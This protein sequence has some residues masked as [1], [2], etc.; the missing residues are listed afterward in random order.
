MTQEKQ[1]LILEDIG[2]HSSEFE[3]KLREAGLDYQPVWEEEKSDPERVEIIVHVKKELMAKN[4][5]KYPRLKL[6]AVAF[7]GFD[8][9]DLE[10]CRE[11]DI[12]VYNVPAYSTHSVTELTIG[13]AIALFREIPKSNRIIREGKWKIK[14]GL[15]IFGKKVGI[16]GTGKIGINTA[17]VFKALGCELLGW[18]RTEKDEFKALG[19]T[20]IHDKKEF[21]SQCD[22][23]SIHLPFNQHT[24]QAVGKEELSAM[25]PTAYLINTARG[26]IVDEKALIE[27]LTNNKIAGAG[28]D[29]FEEEPIQQNNPLLALE[30]VILT[31]HIAFK[32][33]EA[34]V[35]RAETTIQNIRDFTDDIKGNRVN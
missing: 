5:R 14:P 9:V 15:E 11:H 22:I 19:G 12:A 32:T 3:K 29:V 23:V 18:S 17:R 26:S 16:M 1:L 24:H 8:S 25:K 20:Y 33:E 34:L 28:L 4:L 6:I 10:Y 31:P 7:T 27:V 21:F 13:L 30:N 2:V 35:R